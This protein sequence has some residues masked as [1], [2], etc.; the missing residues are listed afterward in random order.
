MPCKLGAGNA[1]GLAHRDGD[2]QPN[3][4]SVHHRNSPKRCNDPLRPQPIC[5][6]CG[7]F[8]EVVDPLGGR[9]G[10]AVDYPLSTGSVSLSLALEVWLVLPL[11]LMSL[12]T[13]T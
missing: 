8:A 9:T 2:S 10:G 4:R 3:V 6:S 11:P 5:A 13:Q 1:A 12:L 7:M